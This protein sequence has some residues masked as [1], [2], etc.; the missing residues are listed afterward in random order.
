MANKKK[1]LTRKSQLQHFSF[2]HA[3]EEKCPI[4]L[5]TLNMWVEGAIPRVSQCRAEGK[6]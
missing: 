1:T 3:L 4:A 2:T 5:S 6:E